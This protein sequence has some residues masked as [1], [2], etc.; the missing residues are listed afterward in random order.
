MTYRVFCET[1]VCMKTGFP[2]IPADV[3]ADSRKF[4]LTQY[5]SAVQS[6]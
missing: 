2:Q 5:C 4:H 3:F 6:L 1:F